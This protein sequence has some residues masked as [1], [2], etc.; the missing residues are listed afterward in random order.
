M[1]VQIGA[2]PLNTSADIGCL[3][4]CFRWVL[5][6]T[7]VGDGEEWVRLILYRLYCVDTQSYLTD[8]Q[9]EVI[10]PVSTSDFIPI[11]FTDLLR[12]NLSTRVPNLSLSKM[13]DGQMKKTVRLEY[14]TSNINLKD[15]DKNIIDEWQSS[16][17]YTVVNSYYQH[18]QNKPEGLQVGGQNFNPNVIFN[19][20][21]QKKRL[22]QDSRDYYYW[23][24]P[25]ST[26]QVKAKTCGGGNI[27]ANLTLPDSGDD[28]CIVDIG[29]L[30]MAALN[31][32]IVPTGGPQGGD[33]STTFDPCNILYYTICHIQKPEEA[34]TYFI[35]KCCCSKDDRIDLYFL[36]PKGGYSLMSFECLE[37]MEI[38][39]TGI[40]VCRD[41]G[42]TSIDQTNLMAKYGTQF[43]YKDK[44][45]R[46]KLKKTIKVNKK[47]REF[48]MAFAGSGH[49][50]A[51]FTCPEE[52]KEDM[53]S[54]LIIETAT[55]PIYEKDSK[56]TIEIT[57]YYSHQYQ[58]HSSNI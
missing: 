18:W 48:Y 53:L 52:G 13:V 33:L 46:V 24:G 2:N 27:K 49:Y 43:L 29:P 55:I 51:R 42:C 14:T 39:K 28:V 25:A 15:C 4:E 3:S 37:S 19:T 11:D 16:D 21:P 44:W 9:G 7:D 34:T 20:L 30:A 5:Y 6:S 40:Q 1:A 26:M 45:L 47:N 10:K 12:C 17:E 31:W 22:C 50:L 54:G 57:G 56:V 35:D 36:D 41:A 32:E 23:C 8:P 58:S 38:N